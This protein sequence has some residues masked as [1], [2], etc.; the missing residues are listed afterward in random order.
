MARFRSLFFALLH[1]SFVVGGS[2]SLAFFLTLK[3]RRFRICPALSAVSFGFSI[4]GQLRGTLFQFFSLIFCI[5]FHIGF[6]TIPLNLYFF[7][8]LLLKRGIQRQNLSKSKTPLT[9]S[10]L[11]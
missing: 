2:L 5:I 11:F 1:G 8:V 6:D 10:V 7:R 4:V 3:R 9:V